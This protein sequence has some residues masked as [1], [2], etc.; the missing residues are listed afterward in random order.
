MS[1]PVSALKNA[2]YDAGIALISEVAPMGMIITIYLQDTPRL[3]VDETTDPLD[4]ASSSQSSD[5][6]LGNALNKF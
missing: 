1:E 2:R 3:F 6:W 4:S 5:S